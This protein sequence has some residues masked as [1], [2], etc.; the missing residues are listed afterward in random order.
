MYIIGGTASESIA[1]DLCKE[2][3]AP[4]LK[5]ISKRF[6]DGELYIRI[7]EDISKEHVIII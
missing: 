7:L 6:P 4:Y 5:N 1:K 2:L 3:K